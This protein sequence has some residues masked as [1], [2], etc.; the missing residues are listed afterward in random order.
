MPVGSYQ[1]LGVAEEGAQGRVAV[2][3]FIGDSNFFTGTIDAASPGRVELD[4]F[5]PIQANA[6]ACRRIGGGWVDVLVR[7]E[8]LQLV[9]QRDVPNR[10]AIKITVIVNYGD[11]VLAIGDGG[12]QVIRV[13]IA[14]ALPETVRE[15]A[16]VTVGWAP[17]DEHLIVR[18][19]GGD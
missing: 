2:G 3:E 19:A 4:R 12:G 1:R 11:S 7:P 5:G 8:R 15:G 6:E 9:G 13:R 10:L 18:S 17:G 14:G 16:T